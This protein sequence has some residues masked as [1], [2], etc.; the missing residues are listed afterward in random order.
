VVRA[1]ATAIDA[2]L[3]IVFRGLAPSNSQF[4]TDC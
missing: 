4:N 2:S 1:L 3:L